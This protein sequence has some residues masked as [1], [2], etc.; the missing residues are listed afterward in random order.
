MLFLIRCSTEASQTHNQKVIPYPTDIQGQAFPGA[1]R[2]QMVA[3][4]FCVCFRD[5]QPFKAIVYNFHIHFYTVCQPAE[6]K[7][8]FSLGSSTHCSSNEKRL[9]PA[10]LT[11]RF[12]SFQRLP[13]LPCPS[14]WSRPLAHPARRAVPAPT[15]SRTGGRGP[16]V[17]QTEPGRPPLD[18][19]RRQHRPRA[20]TSGR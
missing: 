13:N 18:D 12:R 9:N 17:P 19:A 10:A 8:N 14:R 4:H 2:I 7:K 1:S 11:G 3:F 5:S 15:G 20:G 6:I 16:R